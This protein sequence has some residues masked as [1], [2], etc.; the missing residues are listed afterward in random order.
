LGD[1]PK[2]RKACACKGQRDT[3]RRGQTYTPWAG[4]KPPT[5]VSRY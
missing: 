3:E 2:R 1:R 5:L 4:F